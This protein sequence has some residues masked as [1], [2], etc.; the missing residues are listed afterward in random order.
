MLK[1]LFYT[2]VHVS[3]LVR[4]QIS[5]IDTEAC[6]LFI[7]HGKGG[8]DRYILFP[9]GFRLVLKGHESKKSL[10]IYQ[11]PSL[12]TTERA[13][14]EAVKPLGIRPTPPSLLI[15]MRALE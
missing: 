9:A 14:Q 11:H 5:D 6:K 2:V 12:Q 8:K 1:L 13:Y 7:D 15:G 10:E 3:E 4:I